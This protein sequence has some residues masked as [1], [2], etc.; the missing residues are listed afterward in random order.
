MK[1]ILGISSLLATL[2]LE[3]G[4]G[5]QMIIKAAICLTLYVA[6]GFTCYIDRVKA[7][8]EIKHIEREVLST[9]FA[10]TNN[11]KVWDDTAIEPMTIPMPA[12]E[13][14]TWL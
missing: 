14:K 7:D 3:G 10:T 2:M 9:S 6:L 1:A 5:K 13:L 12:K 8:R 4:T 11:T